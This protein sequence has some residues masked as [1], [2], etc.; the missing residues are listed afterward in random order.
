MMMSYATTMK[1]GTYSEYPHFWYFMGAIHMQ[2]NTSTRS[3]KHGKRANTLRNLSLHQSF[4][5]RY[6]GMGFG[7]GRRISLLCAD[8]VVVRDSYVVRS[9]S[10]LLRSGG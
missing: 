3:R 7:D 2:R 8:C 9:D 1:M 5:G 10:F 6:A 4:I